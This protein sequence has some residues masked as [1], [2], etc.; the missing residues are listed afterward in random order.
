MNTLFINYVSYNL[1]PLSMLEAHR[2]YQSSLGFRKLR[3]PRWK[4]QLSDAKNQSSSLGQAPHLEELPIFTWEPLLETRLC[5][6]VKLEDPKN[7]SISFK[8]THQHHSTQTEKLPLSV[9]NVCISGAGSV[10][11]IIMLLG[12]FLRRGK[13]KSNLSI[14]DPIK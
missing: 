3:Y 14:L 9:A 1:L 12:V 8:W 6:L 2:T 11:S 10:C 7:Q 13:T 4:T 5:A